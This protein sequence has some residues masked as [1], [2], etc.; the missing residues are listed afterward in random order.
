MGVSEVWDVITVKTRLVVPA[1]VPS[2]TEASVTL[3]VGPSSFRI[4]PTADVN[5][6]FALALTVWALMIGFA[7]D[8]DRI[9]SPNEKYDLK[10]FHKGI[11]SWARI[12]A[13]LAEA[14]R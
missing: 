12:L 13:A 14:P 4:V 2:T 5:T 10:S 8:D 1:P 7:L 11:R 3:M 6:T 9:H